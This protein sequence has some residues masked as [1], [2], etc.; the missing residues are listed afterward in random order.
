MFIWLYLLTSH[1][2]L[3]LFLFDEILSFTDDC[4]WFLRY[5]KAYISLYPRFYFVENLANQNCYCISKGCKAI[6][7]EDLVLIFFNF[8]LN[9]LT[10]R[11]SKLLLQF[12]KK[13][14]KDVFFLAVIFSLWSQIARYSNRRNQLY[15]RYDVI[16]LLLSCLRDFNIERIVCQVM[17][18]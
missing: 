3:G 15:Q 2:Y 10:S 13:V 8:V 5:F 14:V 12:R 1:Q 4:V 17:C 9:D 18:K 6:K 7:H 16:F 11:K